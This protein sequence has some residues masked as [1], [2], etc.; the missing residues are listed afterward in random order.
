VN[1][2]EQKTSRDRFIEELR[3]LKQALQ[4]SGLKES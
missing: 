1:P 4:H 3:I 2:E